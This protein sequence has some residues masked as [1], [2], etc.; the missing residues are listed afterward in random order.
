MPPLKL[1]NELQS[2]LYHVRCGQSVLVFCIQLFRDIVTDT[3]VVS[4]PFLTY[5]LF[6]YFVSKKELLKTR[7]LVHV[8]A[9]NVAIDPHE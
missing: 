2:E 6:L 9:Y 7:F 1:R 3:F 4:G 8:S 5:T